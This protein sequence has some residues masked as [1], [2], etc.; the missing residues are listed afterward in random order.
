MKINSLKFN[1]ITAIVNNKELNLDLFDKNDRLFQE[2]ACKA[3]F[4][5]TRNIDRYKFSKIKQKS[6]S[7][8]VD[9]SHMHRI[10]CNSKDHRPTEDVIYYLQ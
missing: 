8:I 1:E 10:K 4:K 7:K 2:D 5:T 9:E 6:R 3:T